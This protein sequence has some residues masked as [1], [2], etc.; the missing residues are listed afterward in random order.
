[1]TL[2]WWLTSFI[3]R[4]RLWTCSFCLWFGRTNAC[5]RQILSTTLVQCLCVIHKSVFR[6]MDWGWICLIH[7]RTEDELCSDR[8]TDCVCFH[9]A[10]HDWWS[11][12]HTGSP[13]RSVIQ[14]GPY[15]QRTGSVPLR[16]HCLSC[17]SFLLIDS[18]L[19]RHYTSHRMLVLSVSSSICPTTTVQI[20]MNF[21]L[22]VNGL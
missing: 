22:N 13:R 5:K 10:S 16:E 17:Q 1:M 19:V 11:V 6:R 14:P 2:S 8:L 4:F 3:K 21:D 15:T 12:S 9:V 20:D 7:L 18:G